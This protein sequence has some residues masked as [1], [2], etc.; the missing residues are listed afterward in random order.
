MLISPTDSFGWAP[1]DAANPRNWLNERYADGPT[2]TWRWTVAQVQP[3]VF[4]R[5]RDQRRAY[6]SLLYSFILSSSLLFHL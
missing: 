4:E 6:V 3:E 1:A 2:F 5:K